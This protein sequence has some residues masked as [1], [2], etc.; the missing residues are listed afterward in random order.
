LNQAYI[1]IGSNLGD[2]AGQV[3]AAVDELRGLG[4]VKAV[5]SIYLSE[6]WGTKKE[7]PHFVNAVA[8]LETILTPMEL[9]LALKSA[10]EKLGREPG[11]ERWGP[12]VIDFDILTYGKEHMNEPDLTIPHPHM[13][14]RA[15]VL[16]PLAE[17]DLS[18]AP[19]RDALPSS[20]RQSVKRLS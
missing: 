8:S 2:P 13:N 5:S 1:G 7:Q 12:R 3:R 10:E 11:G 15:F 19:V 9:L 20:E 17:I 16:I 14:E 4:E 18:Y 6:P